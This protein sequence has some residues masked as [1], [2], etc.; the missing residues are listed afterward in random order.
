MI[1]DIREALQEISMYLSCELK[2]TRIE[3]MIEF[4]PKDMAPTGYYIYLCT[5][6]GSDF[7]E[8]YYLIDFNNF[9]YEKIF[10]LSE[11]INRN[12]GSMIADFKNIIVRRP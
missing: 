1:V 6:I 12:V 9:D 7:F 2:E 8:R 3:H 5:Q 10:S 4:N 11:A